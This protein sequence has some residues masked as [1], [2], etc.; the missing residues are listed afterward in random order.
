[1][2]KNVIKMMSFSS[3]TSRPVVFNPQKY[4]F[5]YNLL[6]VVLPNCPCANVNISISISISL[7]NKIS[8]KYFLTFQPILWKNADKTSQHWS[9]CV[10]PKG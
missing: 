7:E 4:T 6:V 1:M 10:P 2:L 9:S 5:K 3:I 8:P